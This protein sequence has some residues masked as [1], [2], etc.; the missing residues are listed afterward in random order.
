MRIKA[1]HEQHILEM[2]T[3][4]FLQLNILP[5]STYEHYQRKLF[6]TDATIRQVAVPAEATSRDVDM[7]TDVI[8]MVDKEMQ[9]CYDDDTALLNTIDA[10]RKKKRSGEALAAP[11]LSE[12]EDISHEA[13]TTLATFLQRTGGLMEALLS[14]LSPATDYTSSAGMWSSEW[15]PCGSDAGSGSMELLRTRAVD[16]VCVGSLQG[17]IGATHRFDPAD[18]EDL[19]PF[20]VLLL[21]VTSFIQI[22]AII[23]L[24]HC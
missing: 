8:E 3:E 21:S 11:T 5:C 2:N 16:G 22:G 23:N 1:L 17:M 20:K 24:E 13:T 18:E 7:N 4:S 12:P 6:T 9:F 14:D 10:I 19:R 15:L